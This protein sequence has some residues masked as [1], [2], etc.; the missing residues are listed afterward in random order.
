MAQGTA[1]EHKAL[2]RMARQLRS[3]FATRPQTAAGGYFVHRGPQRERAEYRY[4]QPMHW[5]TLTF[6]SDL[7]MMLT[8]QIEWCRG[9]PKLTLAALGSNTYLMS[10][11]RIPKIWGNSPSICMH[12]TRMH[13]APHLLLT[14]PEFTLALSR[15]PGNGGATNPHCT[16]P[17]VKVSSRGDWQWLFHITTPR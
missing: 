14:W 10:D 4:F 8:S 15:A 17:E 9:R 11:S 1:C 3:S 5:H 16:N 6:V 13:L 12:Q 7:L 2:A